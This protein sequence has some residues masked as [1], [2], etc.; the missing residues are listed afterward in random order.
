MG[1]LVLVRSLEVASRM[2]AFNMI[3]VSLRGTGFL[4]HL[5]GPLTAF[6]VLALAKLSFH[7][8][9]TTDLLVS[10]F[11]HPGQVLEPQSLL[12][13]WRSL[14]IHLMVLLVAGLPQ[15][16]LRSDTKYQAWMPN[17]FDG[18]KELPTNLL[19][20]WLLTSIGSLL[21]LTFFGLFGIWLKHPLFDR[22]RQKDGSITFSSLAVVLNSK[23]S[24]VPKAALAAAVNEII[25]VDGGHLDKASFQ[26]FIDSMCSLSV[27]GSTFHHLQSSYTGGL[28]PEMT[29]AEAMKLLAQCNLV[30]LN[31]DSCWEI[32]MEEWQQLRGASW[33]L[34]KAHFARCFN[35]RS[36]GAGGAEILMEVLRTCP[37]EELNFSNCWMIPSQA[38]QKLRDGSAWRL[39]SVNLTVCFDSRS[40]GASGAEVLMEVLQ[41]C[42][43]TELNCYDCYRISP[44]AWQ[45][46]AG[47]TWHLKKAN[48]ME[49]FGNDGHG[50]GAETLLTILRTCPLEECLWEVPVLQ[51]WHHVHTN[52][53]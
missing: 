43:L 28:Q 26:E 3:H 13:L 10:L 32:R 39:Q 53:I 52:V 23:G 30:W 18:A 38:W 40:R 29:M 50:G 34:K 35:D 47:A 51:S 36:K 31:L 25:E 48:F 8:A 24:Q 12:P 21:G 15:L 4:G 1:G 45:R 11:G 42:P 22:V 20:A 17:A 5:S 16:L 33:Q 14:M 2:A 7:E 41:K 9:E 19:W 44:S 49:C 6:A 37:L 46:L 27:S